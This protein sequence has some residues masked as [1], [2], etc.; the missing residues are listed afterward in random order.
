[1]PPELSGWQRA[2]PALQNPLLKHSAVWDGAALFLTIKYRDQE[3]KDDILAA[4][5]AG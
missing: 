4:F 3:T 5:I 1:V 2:R